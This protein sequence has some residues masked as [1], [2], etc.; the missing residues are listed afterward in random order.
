M[1]RPVDGGLLQSVDC[2]GCRRDGSTAVL[3][4]RRPRA[5][6]VCVVYVALVRPWVLMRFFI[7]SIVADSLRC[8]QGVCYRGAAPCRSSLDDP[9]CNIPSADAAQEEEAAN[10]MRRC[11]RHSLKMQCLHDESWYGGSPLF[12]AALQ[13]RTESVSWLLQEGADLH[14]RGRGGATALHAAASGLEGTTVMQLLLA[15]GASPNVVDE[16]GFTP[17]HRAIQNGDIDGVTLLLSSGANVSLAAPG[18]SIVVT[19]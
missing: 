15:Q 17:L 5:P 19:I 9:L 13:G 10:A 2:G 6:Y 8:D 12:R 3:W 7:I 1:N 4:I 11:Q 14:A 16:Y 18:V